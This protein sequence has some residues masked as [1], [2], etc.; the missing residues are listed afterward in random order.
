MSIKPPLIFAKLGA[1]RYTLPASY[2]VI[3]SWEFSGNSG[4]TPD[5]EMAD[6]FD[7]NV[8]M[9]D[10]SGDLSRGSGIAGASRS[11]GFSSNGFSTSTTD[12]A[13]ALSD[14]DFY[15]FSVAPSS[16][17]MMNLSSLD[18]NFDTSSTAPHNW[19]LFSSV[20][21]F[22]SSIDTF[23]ASD[24]GASH[25]LD[26]S[27]SSFNTLTSSVEF[28]IVGHGAS[29]GGGTAA[30]IGSGSDIVLNGVTSAIPEPSTYALI[31]GGL[32]LGVVVW[33]RRRFALSA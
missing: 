10:P 24:S 5:P 25:N 9:T 16:G 6:V 27:D 8:S 3:V 31:F 13:G 19:G 18:L 26:L 20:D 11:D 4:V 22:S 33:K 17:F 14:G 28:R 32:A 30:F 23:T 29:S 2:Q 21:G 15:S 7:G 12:F 1:R